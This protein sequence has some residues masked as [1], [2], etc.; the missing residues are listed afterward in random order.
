MLSAFFGPIRNIL[1]GRMLT[2]NDFGVYSLAL[3]IIGL[4]Y[5]IL[6]F[7]QQKGSIRFFIKNNLE[8]Y[9][10]KKPILKLIYVATFVATFSLPLVSWYYSLQFSFTYYCIVVILSSIATELFSNVVRSFGHYELAIFLQRFVRII[11]VILILIYFLSNKHTLP[12]MFYAIG[13]VHLLYGI[14]IGYYVVNKIK[15]GLKKVPFHSQKEG[16]F[17]FVLDIIILLNAYGVNLIIA[18]LLTIE[19]L[20]IFFAISI[21]LRPYEAFMQSTDF[22]MMPSSGNLDKKGIILIIIKNI[23]IGLLIS[24]FFFIIGDYILSIVYDE[25]YNDYLYLLPYMFVLGFIKMMDIIPSSVIGGISNKKN[26]KDY[27]IFNLV[28]TVLFI[29]YSIIFVKTYGLIGAVVSLIT[30]YIIK[31]IFGFTILYKKFL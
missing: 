22:I 7:G 17:F 20:G 15:I 21:V 6:L 12:S 19:H 31:T 29:P 16:L 5:P 14:F 23:V 10:W 9:D 3:T 27:V 25:K 28:L 1:I 11:I 4:L 2:I 26:L 18:S 13:T 24:I 30:L 8:D